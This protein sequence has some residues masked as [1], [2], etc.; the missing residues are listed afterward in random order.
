MSAPAAYA[1][2]RELSRVRAPPP[3]PNAALAEMMARDAEA[4]GGEPFG[5]YAGESI[6]AGSP[7]RRRPRHARGSRVRRELRVASPTPRGE[8]RMIAVGLILDRLGPV[9]RT[10]ASPTGL[11]PAPASA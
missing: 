5:G 7:L 1:D 4:A 2:M 9:A 3:Q 11:R 8:R 6:T 10:T